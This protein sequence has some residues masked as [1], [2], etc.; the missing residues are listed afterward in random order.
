MTALIPY[1][2]KVVC[3]YLRDTPAVAALI[4]RRAVGKTPDQTF[5]PWVRV[6]LLD[7]TDQ[8]GS[9]AEHLIEGFVQLDCYASSDNGQPEANLLARTVR[10]ALR[11]MPG[12]RGDAVVTGTKITGFARLPDLDFKPA[13]ERFV[14]DAQIWAH[15]A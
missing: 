13:R 10:A 8:P 1:F 6:T 3:D 11:D 5:E 7:A 2:E 12:T 14:I 9:R 15:P 4:G